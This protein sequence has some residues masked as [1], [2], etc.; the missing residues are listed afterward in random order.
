MS[1]VL[2]GLPPTE[3]T[4]ADVQSRLAGFPANR[5]RIYPLPGTAVERD[6]L[7]AEARSNRICELIDGTL[8]E[9]TM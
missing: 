8:V 6:V 5:I 4:V 3:W 7:E 2:S 9:K 1:T